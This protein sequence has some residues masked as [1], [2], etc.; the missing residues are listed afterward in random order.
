MTK[1]VIYGKQIWLKQDVCFQIHT[2]KSGRWVFKGMLP[3]SQNSDEKT[4]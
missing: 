4:P 1:N 2:Q 3:P